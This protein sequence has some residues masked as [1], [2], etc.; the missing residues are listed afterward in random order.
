V[1][2]WVVFG[3]VMWV[4]ASGTHGQPR[5]PP[6]RRRPR[7]RRLS[8]HQAARSQP[9][10]PRASACSASADVTNRWEG[11]FKIDVVVTATGGAIS[12]WTVALDLGSATVVGAWNS[13]L[14]AGATDKVTASDLGYNGAVG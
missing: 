11:D 13:T 10:R 8:R 7:P 3:G 14:A 5:R 9:S 2:A 12:D 6:A 4:N 1:I